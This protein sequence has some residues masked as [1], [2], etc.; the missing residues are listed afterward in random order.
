M[1]DALPC[2]NQDDR[3]LDT[4]KF[5]QI[6]NEAHRSL[7]G[8]R[9]GLPPSAIRSSPSIH[10]HQR[11]PFVLAPYY[12]RANRRIRTV[13]DCAGPSWEPED[14]DPSDSLHVPL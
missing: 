7:T 2:T 5:A 1:R 8:R 13:I 4:R 12:E 10:K 3:P 9:E 14:M 11:G 6:H